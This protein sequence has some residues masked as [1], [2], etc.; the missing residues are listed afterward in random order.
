[1]HWDYSAGDFRDN[2][3]TGGSACVLFISPPHSSL[4]SNHANPKGEWAHS[5]D[6]HINELSVRV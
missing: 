4:W 3:L 1:M 2:I 6:Y 5:D